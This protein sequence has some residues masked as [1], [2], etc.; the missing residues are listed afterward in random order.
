MIDQK[1][2]ELVKAIEAKPMKEQELL[3]IRAMIEER[4]RLK[5]ESKE[6]K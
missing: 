2:T 3:L 5:K 4:N 1:T 6:L